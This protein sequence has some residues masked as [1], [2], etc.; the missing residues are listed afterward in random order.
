[1]YKS[2][3]LIFELLKTVFKCSPQVNYDHCFIFAV[4]V[5]VQCDAVINRIIDATVFNLTK[6]VLVKYVYANI[7]VR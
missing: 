5:G 2:N 6:N 4:G 3:T 7:L 1:M